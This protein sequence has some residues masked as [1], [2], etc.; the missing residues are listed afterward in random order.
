VTIWL[1]IGIQT[2]RNQLAHVQKGCLARL[3]QDVRSDGS[4]IEG[5]HKGWNSLQWSF[6]SGIELITALAHDF[7]LRRNCRTAFASKHPNPF[8]LSSHGSHHVRLV[9]YIAGLWN[10]LLAKEKG[11]GSGKDIL[12]ELPR[13]PD[14]HSGEQFGLV[15]S[16]YTSSFKGLLEIKE[17][18]KEDDEF[19]LSSFDDSSLAQTFNIQKPALP[20]LPHYISSISDTVTSLHDD[21]CTPIMDNTATDSPTQWFPG[22]IA[23]QDTPE[24]TELN[25]TSVQNKRKSIHLDGICHSSNKVASAKRP[26]LYN[27]QSSNA[28]VSLPV[29]IMYFSNQTHFF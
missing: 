12:E 11:K 5:S 1:T 22:G 4:R 21:D 23:I 8:T 26:C 14:V 16:D 19:D 9:N 28:T 29:L 20:K 2:H 25:T 18:Y 3:R 15:S 7:V 24:A 10:A 17:E 6:A 27:V 13:L